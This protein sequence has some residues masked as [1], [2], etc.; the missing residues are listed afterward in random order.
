MILTPDQR[1]R[2]FISSTLDLTEERAAA[3][4][5]VEAL[6][7]TTVMFEAGA[8]PHPP[9]ALYSAYVRQSD[10]FVAIYSQRYGWTAPGM[11]VSGL[12]DEFILSTGMPRLVYIRAGVEREPQLNAFLERV[13][14][15]GLSYKPFHAAADLEA[16]LRSDLVVLL[17]ERFHASDGA[18]AV[19]RRGRPAPLPLAPTVF[20]GREADVA[21]ITARLQRHDVRLLTL[22]GPGGTG[23]TRLAIEA[24]RRLEP[25]FPDATFYV[26][27]GAARAGPDRG[28]GRRRA[29]RRDLRRVACPCRRGGCHRWSAHAADPRQLRTGRVRCRD[30]RRA[31][32]DV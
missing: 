16:L 12:E 14:D 5:S 29:R 22:V 3:R 20:L 30:R 19:V 23:K 27:G 13:R 2:V 31:D 28:H 26:T 24:G 18:G 8:R 4:R 17:T 10:V 25:R 9:R 1:L 11:E 32:R 15:A 6:N 7:L 21:E